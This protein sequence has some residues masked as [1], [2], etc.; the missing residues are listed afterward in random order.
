MGHRLVEDT[1]THQQHP[2]TS[3]RESQSSGFSS[4][5][6]R[7]CNSVLTRLFPEVGPTSLGDWDLDDILELT[8]IFQ[9]AR[10]AREAD[11]PDRSLNKNTVLRVLEKLTTGSLFNDHGAN[12][13]ADLE[14][15]LRLLSAVLRLYKYEQ[16]SLNPELR[17]KLFKGIQTLASAFEA[18]RRKCPSDKQIENWNVA[19]LIR[20]CQALLASI[21]DSDSPVTMIAKRTMLGVDGALSGYGGQWVDAKKC[22]R[23]ITRF[24][25]PLP[26]WY[27]E[28]VRL[29]DLCF[30]LFARHY[31]S[32]G[33]PASN[34]A[35]S[36]R[37]KNDITIE[38][39][40]TA[41][42][43]CDSLE[44]MLVEDPGKFYSLMG[45]VQKGLGK[46]TQLL[47]DC[48]VYQE[49]AEYF[50]YG[51]M[52]LMHQMTYYVN[53]RGPCF[54]EFVRVVGLIL[55]RSHPKANSLQRKA[56]DL[57]RRIMDL[58]NEDDV[59]YGDDRDRHIVQNWLRK[60]RNEI[61]PRDA[62]SKYG[63]ILRPI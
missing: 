45:Q 22:L 17:L 62:G 13:L 43:L 32:K 37:L 55:E 23:D 10:V 25:R 52:D 19:F 28:F 12:A 47:F 14:H 57:Y 39:Q 33:K 61:E 34:P 20:H 27:A 50:Q 31:N 35:A 1:S 60:H 29:E 40:Q 44:D 8:T 9:V 48:G 53:A 56:I 54:K 18:D 46:A 42:I 7:R 49:N 3:A 2:D 21:K 16:V 36:L 26:R 15:H 24:E 63:S 41:L 6:R 59:Q 58:G 11:L 5:L 51:V 4:L 38:E 30:S